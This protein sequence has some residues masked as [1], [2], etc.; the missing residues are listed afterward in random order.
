[1]KN[2]NNLKEIGKFYLIR[3]KPKILFPS[4]MQKLFSTKTQIIK[5]GFGILNSENLDH[6]PET[7]SS[8]S[9]HHPPHKKLGALRG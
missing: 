5:T 6:C 1:M 3:M 8:F 9:V 7:V 4:H 2:N